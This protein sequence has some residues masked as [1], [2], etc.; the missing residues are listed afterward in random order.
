MIEKLL[1]Q[2]KEMEERNKRGRSVSGEEE[3]VSKTP[4]LGDGGE[5]A[6]GGGQIIPEGGTPAGVNEGAG[7][8]DVTEVIEEESREEVDGGQVPE[9]KED[10]NIIRTKYSICYIFW[11]LL[12]LVVNVQMK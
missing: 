12:T 1:K 7:P 3:S 4:R 5:T 9:D 11:E 2:V 6:S 8:R 10:S